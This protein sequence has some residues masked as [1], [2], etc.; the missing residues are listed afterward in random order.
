MSVST[1]CV[2]DMADELLVHIRTSIENK[3]NTH[4]KEN[5]KVDK[6]GNYPNPEQVRE[7]VSRWFYGPEV[8]VNINEDSTETIDLG[9][10]TKLA[11]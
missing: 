8:K 6:E 11:G 3:T 5:I 1:K 4:S 10:L 2:D 7:F 9:V